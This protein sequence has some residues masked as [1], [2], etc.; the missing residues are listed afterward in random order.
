M[1]ARMYVSWYDMYHISTSYEGRHKC[2][3]DTM[4]ST[5]S[6]MRVH[7][8]TRMCALTR[9]HAQARMHARAVRAL[10]RPAGSRSGRVP[11]LRI[12][13]CTVSLLWMAAGAELA[14][15]LRCGKRVWVKLFLLRISSTDRGAV[16]KITAT[17]RP[18]TSAGTS[19]SF[20]SSP[21]IRPRSPLKNPRR[22][23]LQLHFLYCRKPGDTTVRRV[24]I[25]PHTLCPDIYSKNGVRRSLDALCI[26]LHRVPGFARGAHI[27]MHLQSMRAHAYEQQYAI[28]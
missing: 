20:S 22:P 19:F 16:L 15:V 10:P 14:I 11:T 27:Q 28:H 17:E 9:T 23:S 26:L 5:P 1:Y 18:Y 8:Y 25:V 3:A 21:W 13:R 2:E 4:T 7:I 24:P 12:R 6:C